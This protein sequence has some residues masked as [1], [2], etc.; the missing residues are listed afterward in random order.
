M[1]AIDIGLSISKTLLGKTHGAM[2][3]QL[4]PVTGLNILVPHEATGAT[5][6]RQTQTYSFRPRGFGGRR[7]ALPYR[8]RI[9]GPQWDL[10]CFVQPRTKG[11]QE[12]G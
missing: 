6:I 9:N 2:R 10:V 7:G 12:D 1:Q 3:H 11:R 5:R 8:G 4:G